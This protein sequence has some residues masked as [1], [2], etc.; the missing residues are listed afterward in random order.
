MT[1]RKHLALLRPLNRMLNPAKHAEAIAD[2]CV[3]KQK[4]VHSFKYP[5]VNHDAR[6]LVSSL[7]KRDQSRVDRIS[8][9]L[10]HGSGSSLA[11][12]PPC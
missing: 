12:V 8:L 9:Y 4:K 3:I 5:V 6:L 10:Y 2:S 11:L 1:S 7:D